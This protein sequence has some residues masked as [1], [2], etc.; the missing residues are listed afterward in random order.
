[1]WFGFVVAVIEL[2]SWLR[3]GEPLILMLAW[4]VAVSV[5]MLRRPVPS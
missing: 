1:M 3:D 4:V 2:A 5:L